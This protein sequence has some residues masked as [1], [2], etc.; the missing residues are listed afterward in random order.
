MRLLRIAKILFASLFI[1]FFIVNAYAN[2]RSILIIGGSSGIGKALVEAYSESGYK[3]HTT[4][5]NTTP[6]FMP[7]NVNYI[8]ID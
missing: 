4:F 7:N 3:V 5:N 8:K 1:V 2:D 6:K